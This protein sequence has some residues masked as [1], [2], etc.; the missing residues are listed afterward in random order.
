MLRRSRG[1]SQSKSRLRRAIT[2]AMLSVA[3]VVAPQPHHVAALAGFP[4][5]NYVGVVKQPAGSIYN[6]TGEFIFPS[7]IRAADY[8]ANPLGA[9]YVYYA[10][11][12]NPGGV[13]LVYSN[14]LDGPWTEYASNPLISNSWPPHYSVTHVSSPH[15][16]WVQEESKL[17][18]YFHGENSTTRY[19]TSTDGITFTY[20]GVAVN[21]T[22]FTGISEAS[23]TRVFR[24]TMPAKG[25]VWTM[26]LMGNNGGT[27][28]IY[29]AWSNDARTWTTQAGPLISPDA[30]EQ[31]QL[32]GPHYFPWNGKHYVVYHAA[33]GNMHIAEVGPDFTLETHLGVFYDSS[34]AAPDNGRAA[35]PSFYTLGSVIYMF[36]EAGLR[37]ATVIALAKHDPAT[38][39]VTVDN[40]DPTGVEIVGAWS[41]ST[42][43][44][45]F[46]G[47]NYLHDGNAGKGSKSVRLRPTLASSGQY[48]VYLRWTSHTNRATNV[49]IDISHS[50]GTTTRTVDQRTLGGQWVSQGTYSFS[51]GTAGS[52]LIR[53]TGT[54]GYV[55]ADAAKWRYI[56]P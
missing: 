21:T 55:I 2:I 9:Y 30:S 47:A 56:G 19:A 11:H 39:E 20:G 28:K 14:S 34:S 26:L 42:S 48:E 35:A 33:S 5:F 6:P 7:V 24:Y 31:G 37:G 8:F 50:T 3:M 54:N 36:Y 10:P 12:N 25:N 15:A 1:S 18:V 46:Y 29:L 17:F 13:S 44:A 40:S 22:N 32:S 27:R 45:G 49:P 43:V 53:T 51:A 52:L 4:T 41:A 16:V 38:V 23:Y